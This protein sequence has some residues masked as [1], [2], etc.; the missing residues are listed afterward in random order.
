MSN[1]KNDALSDKR[2]LHLTRDYKPL[3][4]RLPWI[5]TRESRPRRSDYQFEKLSSQGKGYDWQEGRFT[6]EWYE[7]QQ[8]KYQ[9][10][11]HQSQGA[12]FQQ[13]GHQWQRA[14]FEQSKKM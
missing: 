13:Y 8:K 14:N 6:P 5:P 9:H 2:K 11:T 12:S 4:P 10:I 3:S 1:P 7:S